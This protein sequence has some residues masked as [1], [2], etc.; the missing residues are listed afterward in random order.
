MFPI[1]NLGQVTT[2]SFYFSCE[3]EYNLTYTA[4]IV[5]PNDTLEYEVNP[6]EFINIKVDDE[7]NKFYI[8]VDTDS[9]L[10]VIDNISIS[11]STL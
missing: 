5:T 1:T 11:Y 3:T 6:E 8:K 4:V 10:F 2:L 9:T 7:I